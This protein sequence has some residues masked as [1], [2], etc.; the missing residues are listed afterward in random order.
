MSSP[1]PLLIHNP[2]KPPMKNL[3]LSGLRQT[4][5]STIIRKI[6][7]DLPQIVIGGY[8]TL[9]FFETNGKIAGYHMYSLLTHEN[10]MIARRDYSDQSHGFTIFADVFD[11]FG[12][13]LLKASIQKAS[14]IILDE[15]GT[16][17]SGAIR[18]QETIIE[19]LE[20]PRVVLGVIKQKDS[21]FLNRLRARNDLKVI[22]LNT[23]NRE[24]E[25]KALHQY[26]KKLI[27]CD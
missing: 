23:S 1:H 14:L 17:E 8:Q 9:P 21:I 27:Q 2:N 22:E 7:S 16:M 12:V 25:G 19:C 10:Q 18:F 6:I 5:K 11:Q 13:D 4:G 3:F 24:Q 15:I 26:V 20:L